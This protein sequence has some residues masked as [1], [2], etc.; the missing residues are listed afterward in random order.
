[1]RRSLR[2]SH[3][4]LFQDESILTEPLQAVGVQPTENGG[5]VAIT[6]KSGNPQKPAQNLVSVTY[7][8][9]TSTRK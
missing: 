1:M 3:T 7:G 6:K 9:S 4:L 2:L 5:V 8:P